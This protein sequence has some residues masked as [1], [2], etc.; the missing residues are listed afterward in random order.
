MSDGA[1][2]KSAEEMVVER[3]ESEQS[4][5]REE[6]EREGERDRGMMTAGEWRKMRERL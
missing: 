2:E 1:E 4:E 5:Q 6:S 3:E